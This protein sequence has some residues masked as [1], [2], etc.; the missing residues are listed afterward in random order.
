MICYIWIASNSRRRTSIA[1]HFPGALANGRTRPFLACE[2]DRWRFPIR[3]QNG[4]MEGKIS[5]EVSAL[6]LANSGKPIFSETGLAKVRR[7]IFAIS[8]E[9]GR[10]VRISNCGSYPRLCV[11]RIL[12]T[13]RTTVGKLEAFTAVKQGCP[14]CG[15]HVRGR[16]SRVTLAGRTAGVA[17]RLGRRDPCARF[18]CVSCANPSAPVRNVTTGETGSDVAQNPHEYWLLMP[19]PKVTDPYRFK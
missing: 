19:I 18:C 8:R 14:R 1:V 17:R 3:G 4:W 13:P 16:C 5:I 7:A 10:S 6:I 12:R 15:H 11:R 2:G 9:S